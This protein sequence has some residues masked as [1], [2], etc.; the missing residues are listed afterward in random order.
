MPVIIGLG[1]NCVIK[2]TLRQLDTQ[3]RIQENFRES[4]SSLPFDFIQAPDLKQVLL[5]LQNKFDKF[6]DKDTFN[7]K[8]SHN[9]PR[10]NPNSQ[11]IQHVF[12]NKYGC[13]FMH[14][15]YSFNTDS[16]RTD[17]FKNYDEV[18]SDFE[19]RYE[20]FESYVTDNKQIFF[21]RFLGGQYKTKQLTKLAFDQ[22]SVIL[23][24]K[25]KELYPN[26]NYK[27]KIIQNTTELKNYIS[28]LI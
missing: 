26:L 1:W 24:K 3:K 7:H 12:V 16:E 18:K 22:E 25:L 17:I 2:N 21:I 20:R 11:N 15:F 6:V 27:Y 23:P 14:R 19:R 9:I 8:E 13:K 28:K 5:A 10:N 4:L